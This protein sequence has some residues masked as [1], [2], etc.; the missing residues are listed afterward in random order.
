MP[1]MRQ[2]DLDDEATI[3]KSVRAGLHQAGY[4]VVTAG[5]PQPALA[6]ARREKPAGMESLL[7][8][9][10]RRVGLGAGSR[11]QSA[12]GLRFTLAEADGCVAAASARRHRGYTHFS[13]SGPRSL[14]ATD[15]ASVRNASGLAICQAYSE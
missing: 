10:G 3:V 4:R 9:A 15:S 12:G 6:P 13:N 2:T 14:P 1:L 8:Q 7:S 11:R 5:N